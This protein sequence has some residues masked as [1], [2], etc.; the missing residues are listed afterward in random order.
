MRAWLSRRVLS[1]VVDHRQR[2]HRGGQCTVPGHQF[3]DDHGELGDVGAIPGV[4]VRHHGY[5]AVAGHHQRQPDQPQI[6]AFLFRFAALSDRGAVVGR[7]DVG[8][9]VGHVQH[10]PGQ[11]QPELGDHPPPQL[12]FDTAATPRCPGDPSRP[13]TGGDPTPPPASSPTANPRC[14]P[15]S[16]RTPASSTVRPPGWRWPTRCR[17][18]PTPRHPRGEARPYR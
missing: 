7:V 14:R 1:G 16:R 2:L 9:E 8:G 10:Q 5:P 15:T 6:H 18:P 3:L 4:G 11:V 13:R 17:C 12:G